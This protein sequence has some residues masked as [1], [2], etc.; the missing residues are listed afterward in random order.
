MTEKIKL[1]SEFDASGVR[2]GTQEA[3]EAVRDLARDVQSSADK[4][5]KSV[6]GIGDGAE[7]A[8]KKIERVT[9]NI[10][11]AIDRA[12]AAAKAGERGTAA[13]FETLATQRGANVAAL[14][15]YL[16]QLR[17]VEAA[18]RAATGSLNTMGVS[19]AQTKN[20]LRQLPAQFTDIITSLQGGQAPLTV[21]LQ[22]GGQI[23]DSFGGVGA[24]LRGLAAAINPMV[25]AVGAGVGAV[26]ALALAYKEGAS[27]AQ[28]FRKSLVLTGNA[29][30]TTV[31]R[32]TEASRNIAASVGT[33]GKAAEVL[34]QLAATGKVAAADITK[35]AEAAI[36][37]ERVG[38][39]AA[40]KTVAAFAELGN[41]PLKAAIKLNESTNFLTVELYKQIKALDEHGKAAQA[42]AVAQNAFA[43]AMTG[44]SKELTENLGSIQRAV[45]FVTDGAKGMWDALLNI[46]RAETLPDM[47]EKAR[48]EV[49]RAIKLS[50]LPAFSSSPLADVDGARAQLEALQERLRLEVKLSTVQGERATKARDVIAAD[51][52]AGASH[53]KDAEGLQYLI[54]AGKAYADVITDL[55]RVQAESE[56]SA[57]GYS[58]AQQRILEYFN[59]A[60]FKNASPEMRKQAVAEFEAARAAE[61]AAAARKELQR[62]TEETLK[63][64][65]KWL[66]S[67]DKSI[68]GAEKE[69]QALR[70]Q[71]AEIT[72][73][74]AAREALVQ[75][76]LDDAAAHAQQNAQQAAADG[77]EAAEYQRLQQ[78]ADQLQQVAD[79]RRQLS[80]A[81]AQK[82]VDDANA[83][84]A[85]AAADDWRT[86]LTDAF[87]RSF[88]QGGD[89]GKNFAKIIGNEIKARISAALAE[90]LTA[91]VLGSI[92]LQVAGAGGGGG[93]A[94]GAN[95]LMQTG[96]NLYSLY[97]YGSK[98]YGWASGLFGSGA[99][100]AAGANLGTA[101]G[102]DLAAFYATDAAGVAGS[103]SAGG[104]AASSSFSAVPY[105]GW[106]IAA[107]TVS[108]N[109]YKQGFTN[110]NTN[111]KAID[112]GAA[113]ML[114]LFGPNYVSRG[115]DSL[116]IGSSKWNQIFS[117]AA[118]LNY[119]FGRG[120]PNITAQGITGTFGA[121]DF[122]GQAFA[123]VKQKGGLF[124]SDKNWTELAAL[125]DDIGKFLDTA[126]ASVLAQA[127]DYGKALG[128][129]AEQLTNITSDIK[130]ALTD[131]A[132][133]NE[134]ELKK[135]LS[136][137]GEALVAAWADAVKPL[138]LLNETTATTIQRVAGAI[139]SVNAVL[140]TLGL[141]A[142][143]ASVQGGE[144]AIALQD[145]FGGIG[146][147][148]QAAGNYLQAYY[149]EAER[150][151]LTTDQL[152]KALGSVGLSLPA[153][154]D[155]FR[156]LVEAQD[157]STDA[158]RKA[159]TVL[160]SVAD[161]FA[162]VTEAA[163]SA[164]DVANER[165]QLQD[166]LDQLNGNDAAIKARERAKIDASNLDLYDQ[167]Q[168]VTQAQKDAAAAAAQ[169][170]EAE[171]VRTEALAAQQQQAAA[172]SQAWQAVQDA[173][174]NAAA[175]AAAAWK[176]ARESIRA[177]RDRILGITSPAG[178]G[179]NGAQ[180][181]ALTAAAR[182]GDLAAAQ[183]LPEITRAYVDSLSEVAKSADQLRIMR[184]RV[185]ASLTTTDLL[186]GGKAPGFAGGGNHAGGWRVVGEAGRELEATGP[187]RYWSFDQLMQASANVGS[188]G[189][190]TV[191]ELRAL[192]QEQAQEAQFTRAALMAI[193]QHTSLSATVLDE[194]ARGK[195]PV[196][197]EAVA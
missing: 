173:A 166:Q 17:Q 179:G 175:E 78:L 33:Q 37:L 124:R 53:K 8:S 30:G 61:Q 174:A 54:D 45:K 167:I 43:D 11:A 137:Y 90:A 94:G 158:G 51:K 52:L 164:A 38:G 3:K 128:L 108:L 165:A 82:E 136:G 74:K 183:R 161:A 192:R 110:A 159:F 100:A 176:A 135:A 32:L 21:L 99:S 13:Y 72:L 143:Q 185:A 186:L 141:A 14:Q 130:V 160:M 153:T 106:A 177:E 131:D 69:A 188:G 64:Q 189:N 145:L 16:E 140:D 25:V 22:Q 18:Q 154:R 190:A 116:G 113:G 122:T 170:A 42:S 115:L 36:R 31:D 92:G 163:R 156:A 1:G 63:A 76:R 20:A 4:A 66:E 119:L 34:A 6:G 57:L 35:L 129:P 151:K 102:A 142:L 75:L 67:I 7:G 150:A 171:R 107:L 132:A 126:A 56:A 139:T 127:K 134:E 194:A 81:T 60:A 10:A 87:R 5:S 86:A 39:P 50:K 114:G 40:E 97:N 98:A 12:T 27:E 181:A 62:A 187:A 196:Q 91:Q 178:A 103:A 123:D 104:A 120:A 93:A 193:A 112:S 65:A 125:P 138:A 89:F 101:T 19:A 55:Q 73:G 182:G 118:G 48:K 147:L 49:E 29:A 23:K 28:E 84:A 172:A 24:A 105:I 79:L 197:T 168:S 80:T 77:L 58:K 149:T 88:E 144:A 191:E 46:G 195:R 83:K 152:S 169:A 155:G 146:T 44:R 41:D 71:I 96:Q 117:G 184:L 148:Q 111:N 162:N 121:G 85:K 70:D 47:I 59:S 15:P 109:A 157:I 180:F 26:A 9:G 2:K 95:S 68:E 133:K